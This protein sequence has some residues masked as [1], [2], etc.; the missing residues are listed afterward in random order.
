MK[1]TFLTIPAIAILLFTAAC[2]NNN[3]SSKNST[4]SKARTTQTSKKHAKKTGKKANKA[5]N[6]SSSSSQ[7]STSTD[8][9][10]SLNQQLKAR[11]AG[12]KLPSTYPGSTS[13]LN[14]GY[15]GNGANYTVYYDAG[16]TA[17]SLNAANSSNADIA[18]R[19]TTLSSAAAA[20]GQVN[21]TAKQTGLPTVSLGNAI[22]A[23]KESAA[24]STY[25]TWTE[26]RW[27]IVLRSSNVMGQ[28]G[29]SAASQAVALLHTQ[30]LPVPDNHGAIQLYAG[31]QGS[32]ANTITWTEG[33]AVY[34][35]SGTNFLTTLQVATHLN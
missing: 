9:L 5:A 19:K 2:G 17:G 13:S 7:A 32:R 31:T 26:G 27:S 21:Y 1:K 14:A 8:R 23:T 11:L 18:I 35:V 20:Q 29:Q 12:A 15:E 22:T 6:S 33:S 4:S 28:N 24:G 34:T 16:S 30:S 10:T 3:A 25:Y